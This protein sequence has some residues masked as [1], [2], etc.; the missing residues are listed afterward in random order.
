MNTRIFICTIA[1]MILSLSAH[2]QDNRKQRYEQVKALQ[3]AYITDELELSPEQA[4]SFW[5][6]YNKYDKLKHENRKEMSQL[7]RNLKQ[8]LSE[9]EAKYLIENLEKLRKKELKID[10]DRLREIAGQLG[11]KKTL[12]LM[13]AERS[14]NRQLIRKMKF[15]REGQN[16]PPPPLK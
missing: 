7:M 5:P 10:Q 2:A 14:F 15:E 12:D 1:L 3:T 4:E 16:G 8:D 13:L 6:V 9:E 11:Y